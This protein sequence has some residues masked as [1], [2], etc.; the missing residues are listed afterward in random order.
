MFSISSLNYNKQ[1]VLA[2]ILFSIHNLEKAI[3]FSSFVY[4]SDFPLPIPPTSM[5]LAMS[6]ITII[7][8]GF[9]L[10]ANIQQNDLARKDMLL[11]F[12]TVFVLNTVLPPIA[13]IIFLK[14]YFPGLIT[15]VILY[16]PYS[17]WL[18]PKLYRSYPERSRFYWTATGGLI[19]AGTLV[20]T[21]HFLIGVFI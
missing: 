10:W 4:P 11:I 12:I 15:S 16:L 6:L 9:I 7:A 17:I 18:L 21:L 1:L 5:I 13:A 8:W 3:G 20:I 2:G 14:T 19:I